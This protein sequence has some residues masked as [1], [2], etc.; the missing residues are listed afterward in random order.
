MFIYLPFNL[1]VQDK[2]V[3]WN[4]GWW[5]YLIDGVTDWQTEDG[6]CGRFIILVIVSWIWSKVIIIVVIMHVRPCL[7]V[8]RGW[9]VNH[10]FIPFAF[11][12]RFRNW[13]VGNQSNRLHNLSSLWSP[14]I[15][16]TKV[17]ET[18]RPTPINHLFAQILCY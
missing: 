8:L 2:Y 11:H 7:M 10:I 3:K 4:R 9:T 5:W 16:F 17:N 13:N 1:N 18:D 14:Y 6:T 15:S 12:L